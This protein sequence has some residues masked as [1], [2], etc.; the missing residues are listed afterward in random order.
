MKNKEEKL[1]NY[2]DSLNDERK[3]REHGSEIETA[4]MEEIFKTVRLVRSLK[5]V[6]IPKGNY[7]KK[8]AKNI[9]EKLL[10]EKDMKK[11]RKRWFY[12]AVAAAAVALIITLNTIQPFG[13]TNMVH[14][15]E[16]AF[17]GVKA[18]HGVIE[19]IETN[20]DGKATSL[21][22]VEVWAD[23]NGHYYAKGLEGY[24]KDLITANDGQKKWQ[25]KPLQKE[26]DIFPA[27]PDPYSFAFEL[28]KEINDVKNAIQTKVVGYDTVAGRA[29]VI[30]EV[31][32]QGG[33]SYKIWIDKETKIPLQKLSAMEYSMQYKVHYINIDFTEAIPK[34]LLS[35]KVPTGFKEINTNP[36][37]V[38]NS[39][40]EAKEIAKFAPKLLQSTIATFTE[41]SIA[42]VNGI[43]A[44]KITYN[45]S[46]N[47]KRVSVLQKKATDEFKPAPMAV[48]GKIN[49]NIAEVQTPVQNETGI[50]QGDGIY[51]GVTGVS[52]IR[53]QQEGV[54]YAVVGNATLDE[55]T[56]FVKSL[57]NGTVDLSISKEENLSK[58]KVN[59]T[60]DLKAE[61][62]DQKNADAGHSPWKLDP[63]F[64]AQV[65]V[66][67]KI[68]PN[69]I[70][71]DYPINYEE[72]KVIQNSGREA[73]VEV[74]GNKTPIRRVY[75]KRLIRQD[76][77]GIWTVIGYD[78]VEKK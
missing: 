68:S 10:K 44:I 16:Q 69:G 12:G 43:K 8:L 67:L 25:V 21:S 58:P 54:E 5:A 9:N 65:F 24:Q 11:P 75:L 18:Y 19:V 1:S 59:V 47:K 55:L 20:A 30:I 29:A 76:N 17:S 36:E 45:S 38:V 66:S 50:L 22:K 78:P 64:V 77:T 26:I 2:I 46:D 70:Q 32:P 52:S 56:L 40:E 14:A 37:Q 3:P 27:F 23:K 33:S 51:T 48:L 53:W 13:K 31:T 49:G 39:L 74:S 35:Y 62:G 28:G 60:V 41:N 34:E 4:E 7:A 71:G 57:T 72:L 42:V 15:M 73:I 61:E 63:A 6:N